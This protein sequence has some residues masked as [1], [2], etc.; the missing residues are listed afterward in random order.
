VTCYPELDRRLSRVLASNA[1]KSLGK[2]GD[3]RPVDSYLR[4]KRMT[5]AQLIER[6]GFYFL[7][8][9]AF[10][11]SYWKRFTAWFNRHHDYQY[12]KQHTR[13]LRD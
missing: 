2:N 11:E 13:F 12:R 10:L 7:K 1:T 9:Q 8:K 4:G 5:R 6:D 3:S